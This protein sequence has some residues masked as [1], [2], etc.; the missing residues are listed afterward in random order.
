[1][2]WR[3][4][5]HESAITLGE[6]RK[7]EWGLAELVPPTKAQYLTLLFGMPVSPL[8]H[9]IQQLGSHFG[10]FAPRSR[11]HVK[12]MVC[13]GK[14]LE[15]DAGAEFFAERLQQIE[16]RKLVARALKKK[17]RNSHIEKVLG[18]FG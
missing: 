14:A 8:R 2:F 6:V 3:D 1:M 10:V 18:A 9:G 4:E 17:H 12:G 16:I 5:L 7:T 15:C 13:I 11:R